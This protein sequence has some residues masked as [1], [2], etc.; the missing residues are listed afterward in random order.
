MSVAPAAT[1]SPH[2]LH[3][4]G[5][6]GPAVVAT[7]DAQRRLDLQPVGIAPGR[8]PRGA[9]FLGAG[10][11][12]FDGLA[13]DRD[14]RVAVAHEPIEVALVQRARRST[15][16]R[17]RAAP[18]SVR[19][20]R[21]RNESVGVSSAAGVSRHSALHAASVSVSSCP[22][23]AKS[24]P[25]ASYSSR[26]QPVPTPRS[27]RPCDSTSSVAA[28][29]ASSTAGRSGAIRMPVASRTRV[30]DRGHRRE[31]RQRFEPRRIGRSRELPPRVRVGVRTH[32]DVVDDD[33]PVDAGVLRD[34]REVDEAVPLAQREERA[35]VREPD[36]ERRTS[37]HRAP[38][39]RA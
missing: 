36:G 16:A 12:A 23:C 4:A 20:R 35:E 6:V 33:D 1:S 38:I 39:S 34:P 13:H 3:A 9:R 10:R 15:A 14:P 2:R 18:A 5:D 27:S 31:H 32:H 21:P 29:F 7:R 25:S 19:S 24:R 30:G 26:C 28:C 11:D 37:R 8:L 17:R 22:R